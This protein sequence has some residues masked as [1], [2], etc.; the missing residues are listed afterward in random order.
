[1]KRI[2]E[3]KK[4]DDLEL[5]VACA[6]LAGW[7]DVIDT[8]GMGLIG[9]EPGGDYCAVPD[10]T[11]DLN[12]IHALSFSLVSDFPDGVAQHYVANLITVAASGWSHTVDT[13]TFA[14]ARE[15][16][17]AYIITIEEYKAE[18]GSK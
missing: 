17:I 5:T 9:V 6:R 2:E 10:F 8:D 3:L 15:R 16:T 7:A 11:R 4:L 12:A 18:K 1:M 14:T 13:C